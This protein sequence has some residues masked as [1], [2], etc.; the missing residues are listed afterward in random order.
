LLN[1]FITV[2]LIIVA[3]IILFNV[4]SIKWIPTAITKMAIGALLLFFL[5]MLSGSIGLHV[6][7]NLFT[8]AVV[9]FCGIPGMIAVSSLFLFVI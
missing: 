7:I 5:N 4:K 2:G 3:L 6:P 1:I 8:T 9:G